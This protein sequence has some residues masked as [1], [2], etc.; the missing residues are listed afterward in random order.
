[1]VF[2]ARQVVSLEGSISLGLLL[3]SGHAP[4]CTVGT[5]DVLPLTAR[6]PRHAT[7][8]TRI[9]CCFEESVAAANSVLPQPEQGILQQ[10]FT[11]EYCL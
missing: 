5:A 7:P 4:K 2:A 11:L 9:W 6:F 1:M 3:F 10:S 8:F